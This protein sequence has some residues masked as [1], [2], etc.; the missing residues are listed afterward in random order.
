M[1]ITVRE[2]LQL[3]ELA[4]VTVVAGAAGLGREIKSVNIMEVPDI[5]SYVERGQL[6]LT[7]TYPIS[8]NPEALSHLVPLLAERGL[9]ALAIKPQRYIDE[10]PA[11]MIEQ[12][13]AC[14]F[15][16]LRLPADAAFNHLMN[17]IMTEVLHRQAAL[18]QRSE[19][20][21]RSLTQLVLQGAGV[22]ELVTTVAELLGLPV[23]IA[24]NSFRMIAYSDGTPATV[25]P[26]MDFLRKI[27]EEGLY[28]GSGDPVQRSLWVEGRLSTVLLHP[29]QVGSEVYG[30]ICVW[31]GG[32]EFH[33]RDV[34][35]VE[36]ASIVTALAFQKQRAVSETSRRF[37]D[38]FIRDLITGRVATREEAVGRAGL[39][40]FDP[41]VPRV[42]L[43]VS[44]DRG[45]AAEPLSVE[46][47]VQFQRWLERTLRFGS[48]DRVVVSHF[49][50]R[51]VLLLAPHDAAAE[52]AKLEALDL[53][54]S[55]A[56]DAD[57]DRHGGR[58]PAHIGISR[59]HDD[60]LSWPGAYREAQE[61]LQ[62]GGYVTLGMVSHYDDLGVFRLLDRVPDP[63]ELERFANEVLGELL[64]YDEKFK[65]NLV[66]TLSALIEADGNLQQA[67]ANLFVH[68]NTLRYRLQRISEIGGLRFDSMRD[69]AKADIALKAHR[70]L[71]ARSGSGS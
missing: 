57:S 35:C 40:G 30:Y 48:G 69:M 15:P 7:T 37:R 56:A 42:L 23:A 70:A 61:A 8:D 43:L 33:E 55:L 18:L 50:E 24:D 60:C 47:R 41:C 66:D 65:T 25:D 31:E 14:G 64:Q 32:G 22:E 27:R 26:F 5:S 53:A 36:Q 49:G 16:L 6:L 21:H 10:I 68:Y 3:P 1:G 54:R 9:A 19:E 63:A 2:A 11:A 20:V 39:Y 58:L 34:V 38:E 17:P 12:A 44:P 71:R 28:P 45:K 67:A 62:L 4:N 51:S 29:V 13:E 52:A 46:A 59:V